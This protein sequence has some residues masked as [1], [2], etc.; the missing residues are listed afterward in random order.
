[1]HEDVGTYIERFLAYL[2]I[3]K[4]ASSHTLRSYHR[5]IVDF[6]QYFAEKGSPLSVV[7]I[8]NLHIR[9]YLTV[10]M[11]NQYSR[12]TIARKLSGLRSFYR[13]L[14]REQVVKSNPVKEVSTPKLAKTLP[15]SLYQDEMVSLLNQPDLQTPLGIRDRA[16][17]EL[18]YASGMRV[19]ELVGLSTQS[20][21]LDI[22]VALVFGKGA[23]ERYVP[24]GK[25][26]IEFIQKYLKEVR[27]MLLAQYHEVHDTLFLNSRGGPL[28][29]R[30]VRRI[31]EKYIGSANVS[32]KATPHT[33][34]HSFATH[35]LDGGAD[36]RSVQELLGHRNL[37]TTQIYTHVSKERLRDTYNQSH[38]RA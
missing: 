9:E 7:E 24:I 28:T 23:K 37:S 2:K 8:N 20:L 25:I 11:R 38:P 29:D 17:L 18:L 22:G 32:L 16:I 19:S 30:S 31:V 4:H 36:L 6:Y 34:R 13:F 1:M 3:E 15:K 12:T 21:D 26:A 5:D 33:F 27:P 10:L 14:M 35:L